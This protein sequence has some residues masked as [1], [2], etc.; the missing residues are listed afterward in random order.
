MNTTTQAVEN[1]IVASLTVVWLAA[2]GRD[3]PLHQTFW[4]RGLSRR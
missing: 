4:L 1:A 2:R 3:A